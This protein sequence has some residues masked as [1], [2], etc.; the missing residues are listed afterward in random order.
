MR[1][2][3]MPSPG[4]PPPRPIP[5]PSG[6]AGSGT[7]QTA[8]P[9]AVEALDLTRYLR[10]QFG[11]REYADHVVVISHSSHKLSPGTFALHGIMLARSPKLASLMSMSHSGPMSIP[12]TLHVVV[13][14]RFIDLDEVV[15]K[16]LL[17]LYGEPML[18]LGSIPGMLAVS[19]YPPNP[20]LQLRA[21][22]AYA[23]L[24]HFLQMD[25][26]IV[27]G[28]DLAST[29]LN[30]HN[31]GL[32]LAFAL[33]GGLGA[34]WSEGVEEPT[35]VASV[36][37]SAS[38]ASAPAYGVYSDR[39]LHAVI[40][41]IIANFPAD[42]DFAAGVPQ[43]PE[44]PRLPIAAEP[45]HARSG[46]RLSQIRFGEMTVEE[47]GPEYSILSGVLVS[48]PFAILKH[49]LEH[50][51]LVARLGAARVA[52][53]MSMTVEEREQRRLRVAAQSSASSAAP[54]SAMDERLWNS[55]RWTELVEAV[56]MAGPESCGLQLR[57]RC[58][59]T[60]AASAGAVETRAGH[61]AGRHNGGGDRTPDTF[62]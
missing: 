22:L 38:P 49:V 1:R 44:A 42:F 37:E 31:I 36:D 3:Y 19:G 35:S 13:S 61:E 45:R 7:R 33:E 29:L 48:L 54:E 47:R 53:V 55:V 43:L 4:L 56:P 39:M 26:I 60:P 21:A 32:A 17:H 57:R 34:S 14:D 24:G 12:R 16:G 20:Y 8:E 52:E 41:F 59:T 5:G 9:S 27:R 11:N 50:A 25:A 40:S 62:A 46:S 15:T 28:L 58:T 2:D 10:N 6:N 23:A 30:W 51:S 18:D